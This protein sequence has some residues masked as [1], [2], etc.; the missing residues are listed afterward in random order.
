MPAM[1]THATETAARAIAA[2]ALLIARLADGAERRALT[3]IARALRDPARVARL[4]STE[5][6]EE[7]RHAD[8]IPA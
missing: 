5:V 7:P 2:E 4:L 1:D 6:D 8:S 3:A